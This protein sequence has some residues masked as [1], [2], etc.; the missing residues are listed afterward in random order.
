MRR[1]C[2][3]GPGCCTNFAI[4]TPLPEIL[5]PFCLHEIAVFWRESAKPENGR[6]SPAQAGFAR[7]FG[8]FDA[9]KGQ[10]TQK[11]GMHGVCAPAKSDRAPGSGVSQALKVLKIP[12]IPT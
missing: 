3:G 12:R 2:F 10:I 4:P 11:D 5:R 8:P 7:H 6:I 9:W 1:G